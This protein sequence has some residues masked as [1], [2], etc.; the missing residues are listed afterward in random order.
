MKRYALGFVKSMDNQRVLLLQKVRPDFM[1]GLFNGVG[2]H[3][4][5]G[6]TPVAAMVREC[7]EEADLRIPEEEWMLLDVI[8]DEE[9]FEINVFYAHAEIEKAFARTDEPL[10]VFDLNEVHRLPLAQD[11]KEILEC[12]GAV[13]PSR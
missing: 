4:E 6:E 3:I 9:T 13:W 8:G 5:E 1:A 2:G 10:Q 7:E 12:L 11:C